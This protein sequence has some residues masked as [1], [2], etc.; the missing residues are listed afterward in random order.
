MLVL[1]LLVVEFQ[2]VAAFQVSYKSSGTTISLS[3]G[4]F[5][6]AVTL[7]SVGTDVL[8]LKSNVLSP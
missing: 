7:A 3:D 2:F 1:I 8:L 5:A 4:V 6:N